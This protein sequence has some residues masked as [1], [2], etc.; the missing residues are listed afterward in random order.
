MSSEFNPKCYDF[1][2]DTFKISL[3]YDTRD[4]RVTCPDF[5][6]LL[7]HTIAVLWKMFS[8][9]F[10]DFDQF[11]LVWALKFLEGIKGNNKLMSVEMKSLENFL[12]TLVLHKYTK[13]DLTPKRLNPNRKVRL[14]SNP[15]Y[16]PRSLDLSSRQITPNTTIMNSTMFNDPSMNEAFLGEKYIDNN[17][18]ILSVNF[19]QYSIFKRIK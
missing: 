14:M 19:F 1:Y 6:H 2:V 5:A 17:T 13:S 12:R 18:Q 15:Q 8:K 11:H 3:P 16:V 7:D 10:S 4:I 9:N